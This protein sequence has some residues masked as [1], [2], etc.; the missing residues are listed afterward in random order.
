MCSRIVAF[1]VLVLASFASS[2]ANKSRVPTAGFW[3]DHVGFDLDA[4]DAERIGGPL[5]EGETAAIRSTAL[6][7]LRTAYTGIDLAFVETPEGAYRVVV[8]QNLSGQMIHGAIS[9]HAGE[10][11]TLGPFGGRGMVS[12]S[13]LAANAIHYATPGTTRQEIVSAIGR[14]VGRAAA[15][16]FAHQILPDVDLHQIKDEESYEYGTADRAA[17]Y[18]GTLH[19]AT[20]R[21]LMARKLGG[22]WWQPPL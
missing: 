2:C 17:Q 13:V 20:A 1:A 6:A 16:E 8:L 4:R 3:F 19:W 22:R 21:P 14:G 7:E 12:F 10:S 9:A 11:R 5:N 15:H 18:Y